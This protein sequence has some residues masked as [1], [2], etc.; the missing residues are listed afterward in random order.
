M[1]SES[2]SESDSR[3]APP[4]QAIGRSGF[5]ALIAVLGYTTTAGGIAAAYTQ[6]IGPAA[7][8]SVSSLV[9]RLA[10]VSRNEKLLIRST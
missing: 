9:R 10:F 4:G 2:S 7:L 5:G 3:E 1:S 6:L 8:L